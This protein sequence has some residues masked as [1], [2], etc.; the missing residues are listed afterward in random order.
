MPESRR[1]KLVLGD[2]PHVAGV[3]DGAIPV[4]GVS[5][6]HVAVSSL[7]DAFKRMCRE[8]CFDVCEMSITGY[9]LAK[10][11]GLP[12][13]ALPVFP[14]RGFPQSHA[15]IVV[16][17]DSGIRSPRDLEGRRVG[18]R[19]YTGTASLWVRGV[20]HDECGVDLDSVTWVSAEE[21]HVRQYEA[22]APPNAVYDLDRT[23]E[24][25]LTAGE[26][27]AAIGVRP[28][29]DFVPI[30][31][32]AREA[33]ADFCKRTRIYQINHTIVVRDDILAA[34]PG[35]A[36]ALY[37]AFV[38]AKDRWLKTAPASSVAEELGLPQGDPLPYGIDDNGPTIEALLRYAH[39]QKLTVEKLR[40]REL[41]ICS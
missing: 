18:A 2:Y 37:D 22:D 40:A 35:L 29:E 24:A 20:L 39:Q 13:T 9:L 21:E 15:A 6:D 28:S 1:L 16:R 10:R 11:Y 32:N 41:F 33:A 12:F 26:L 5:F 27:D 14:V 36:R 8:V 34:H 7:Q 17:R 31:P 30:I 4:E 3:A 23:I 19:A 38:D 25:M